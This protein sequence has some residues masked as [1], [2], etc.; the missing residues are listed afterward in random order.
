MSTAFMKLIARG[1]EDPQV[2]IHPID[3]RKE[4]GQRSLPFVLARR[5]VRWWWRCAIDG[6]HRQ[7]HALPLR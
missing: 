5:Y 4:L 7:H 1:H 3:F 2:Q 6:A